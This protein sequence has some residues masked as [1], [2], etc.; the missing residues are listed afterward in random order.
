MS[1]AAVDFSGARFFF[2]QFEEQRFVAL[3]GVCKT[4]EV[5]SRSERV[6]AAA[7]CVGGAAAGTAGG[8]R[9]QKG[10][11]VSRPDPE[12]IHDD[13]CYVKLACV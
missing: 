9:R 11:R 1:S 13:P 8:Q 2:R 4:F 10:Q 5:V 12:A 3:V 6:A 7:V